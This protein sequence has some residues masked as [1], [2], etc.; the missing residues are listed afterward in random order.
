MAD[1]DTEAVVLHGQAVGDVFQAGDKC[2]LLARIFGVGKFSLT[3]KDNSASA[4]NHF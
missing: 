3:V 4:K 2:N 1:A